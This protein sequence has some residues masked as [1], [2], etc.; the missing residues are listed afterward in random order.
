[1][2]NFQSAKYNN[3]TIFYR[4]SGTGRPV[5]L[6][7]GF[8]EDGK[9]WNDLAVKLAENFKVIIPDIPGSGKSEILNDDEKQISIDDYAKVI[10]HILNKENVTTCTIIG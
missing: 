7:H 5:T 2:E 8:G 10:M 1:M 4:I 3:S 9:I 6:V